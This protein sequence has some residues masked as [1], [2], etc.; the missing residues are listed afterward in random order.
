[1]SAI[2]KPGPFKR[3]VAI[4]TN[5][6]RGYGT[7]QWGTATDSRIALPAFA[8]KDMAM[9]VFCFVFSNATFPLRWMEGPMMYRLECMTDN[10]NWIPIYEDFFSKHAFK[11]SNL[12]ANLQLI[13]NEFSLMW[14]RRITPT[15][16][17]PYSKYYSYYMNNVVA[18]D[19][20]LPPGPFTDSS[21]HGINLDTI[22]HDLDYGLIH[23]GYR[24]RNPDMYNPGMYPS[25]L[26]ISNIN[27]PD[28]LLGKRVRITL[29]PIS[30]EYY[31][32]YRSLLL[33]FL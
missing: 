5:P 7:F 22:G 31:Q 20:V 29:F 14:P 15:I 21:D 32:F 12:Y 17:Q 8:G 3:I 19:R 6:L 18:A 4:R 25:S 23:L 1:M 10:E 2:L 28:R 30:D 33:L 27:Q 24:F 26:N 9:D 16:H 11:F 13:R